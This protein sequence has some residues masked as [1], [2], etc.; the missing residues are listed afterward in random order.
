MSKYQKVSACPFEAK[1]RPR[2]HN[3]SST[4]VHEK[5]SVATIIDIVTRVLHILIT[6]ARS[7]TILESSLM[8]YRRFFPPVTLHVTAH[9]A[10]RNSTRRSITHA[11]T[12]DA[13]TAA[14]RRDVERR[15]HLLHL[16][17]RSQASSCYYC[18]L[19]RD[20]E[21]I[22]SRERVLVAFHAFDK[23]TT[24]MEERCNS[25]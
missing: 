2:R 17:T 6:H 21:E 16:Q 14:T 3:I 13:L 11:C 24:R 15:M 25:K 8:T 19:P 23:L 10:R 12:R 4:I 9:A 18:T 20:D 1:C 22:R 5:P 7:R